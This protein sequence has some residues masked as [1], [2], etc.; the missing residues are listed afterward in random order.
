MAAREAEYIDKFANPLPAAKKGY[1]DDVIQPSLTRS[2]IISDLDVLQN[3][4]I[5]N[6]QFFIPGLSARPGGADITGRVKPGGRF[7][8][9]HVP[10]LNKIVHGEAKT[11]ELR[12]H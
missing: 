3:K 7:K 5:T 11:P 8:Q 4:S 2:I 10:F 9:S 6:P 1:V 12:G